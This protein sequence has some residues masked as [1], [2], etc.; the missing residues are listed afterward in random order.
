MIRNAATLLVALLLGGTAA[1]ATELDPALRGLLRHGRA[2]LEGIQQSA[3]WRAPYP[4]AF[5][6]PGASIFALVAN[7]F[8]KVLLLGSLG[9]QRAGKGIMWI[10]GIHLHVR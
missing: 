6:T 1:Q 3:D 5:V 8:F 4:R 9:A 2:D 7:I 10:C